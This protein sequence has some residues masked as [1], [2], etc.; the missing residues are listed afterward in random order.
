[1]RV[2]ARTAN[3]R[4]GIDTARGLRGPEERCG[5]GAPA[6]RDAARRSRISSLPLSV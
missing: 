1:M 5:R 3:E 4:C 2:A 6:L